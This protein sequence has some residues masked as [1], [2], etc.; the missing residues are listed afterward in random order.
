MTPRTNNSFRVTINRHIVELDACKDHLNIFLHENLL[1]E[2]TISAVELAVYEAL[3]NIYDHE[4]KKFKKKP[5]IV[6]CEID[7]EQIVS[8]I[9]Y[10]GN[11]FDITNVVLPD[12]VMHF[13]KGKKRGLGIYFIRTLMDNV[14]YH[15][16]DSLNRIT[17]VK[18]IPHDT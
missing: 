9:T 16:N 3:V 11:E 17:L 5:I 2:E 1:N 6:D 14:T 7:E 13:K 8:T 15:Y 4:S 10:E 18:K 12:I